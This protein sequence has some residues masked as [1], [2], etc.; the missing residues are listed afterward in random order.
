MLDPSQGFIDPWGKFGD[1]ELPSVRRTRSPTLK[2]RFL[3]LESWSASLFWPCDQRVLIGMITKFIKLLEVELP[4]ITRN[5]RRSFACLR[6]QI[7]FIAQARLGMACLSIHEACKEYTRWVFES[8]AEGHSASS[9]C[10]TRRHGL[11]LWSFQGLHFKP[12]FDTSLAHLF[13]GDKR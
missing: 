5:Y 12:R 8:C 7:G 13:V 11:A 9:S 6:P 4:V 1:L 2:T 10:P 3:I